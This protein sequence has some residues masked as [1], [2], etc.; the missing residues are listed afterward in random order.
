LYQDALI[1]LT[2][3]HG[4]E[5]HEHGG[6][7]HGTTLYE[8]QIHVPLVVKL[9]GGGG[10]GTTDERMVRI[11][12]IVPAILN[13]AAITPPSSMQ[14]KSFLGSPKSEWPG[15]ED[16][17]SEED[18]EGNVVRS[19]RTG[20]WKLIEANQGNPRGLPPLCLF[21]LAQDPGEKN[22]LAVERKDLVDLMV[23]RLQEKTALARGE[24]VERQQRDIDE[25]T[26]ERLR[27]LG[28]VE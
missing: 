1:I 6:W 27:S 12:D 21:H 22:N 4:Q 18:H 9:P 10:A 3:D 5:F 13:L 28:Y 23:P 8:E 20:T 7:W 16:V 19:L 11:L 24:A 26:L 15:A 25:A 17:F 14:G 2:A